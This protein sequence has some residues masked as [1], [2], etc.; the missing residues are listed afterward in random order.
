MKKYILLLGIIS[1]L[2]SCNKEEAIYYDNVGR[3]YFSEEEILFSFGDKAL[4]YT[5]HTINV[6]VKILGTSSS[7]QRVFKVRI[8]TEKSTAQEGTHYNTLNQEFMVQADSINSFI[9]LEVLR[10]NIEGDIVLHVTLKILASDD[11]DLGVTELLETKISFNDFLEKP[12][13]WSWMGSS[14]GIYQQEKYQKYIEIHGG[15]I[16]KSYVSKNYLSVMK[17]FKQVKDYFD[18]HPE[19]GVTFPVN[20]WWP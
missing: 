13:W 19:L 3:I 2:Y 18:A 15:P 6:P 8:L 16:D 7:A 11:F 17:E 14:L 1:L 5:T 12:V 10:S 4:N 9:P 20:G